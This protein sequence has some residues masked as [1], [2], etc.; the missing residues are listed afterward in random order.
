MGITKLLKDGK[1]DDSTREAFMQRVFHV[2]WSKPLSSI[3]DGYKALLDG[4]RPVVAEKFFE[5]FGI[6]FTHA[7]NK[8]E[9]SRLSY[10]DTRQV[11]LDGSIKGSKNVNDVIEAR[12]HMDVYRGLLNDAR[13]I[14]RDLMTSWHERLFRLTKQGEAG[15]I[16]NGPVIIT[17]SKHVPPANRVEID[18]H[19]DKLFSWLGN[20][21]TSTLPPAVLACLVMYRL[22]WIHP[23][24]DGNGRISRLAMNHVLHH[25]GYPMFNVLPEYRASYYRALET[26]D[27]NMD[28][29]HVLAW[30]FTHY[31]EQNK[32]Y[33]EMN[34]NASKSSQ[35]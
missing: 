8:I 6:R 20:K 26:S 5:D 11:I 19:L 28:E 22:A 1:I 12:S 17:G 14:T 15:I 27:M 18:W 31:I 2:R 23:F 4:Y 34:E 9:G 25:A 10:N 33:L 32:R 21:A 35:A 13:P 24:Y 29:F 16:R 3:K 30:F 7:S